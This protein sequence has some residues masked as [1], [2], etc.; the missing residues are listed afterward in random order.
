MANSVAAR[1]C[2]DWCELKHEHNFSKAPPRWSTKRIH[3]TPEEKQEVF[4]K[5]GKHVETRDE[6][7]KV[8]RATGLRDAEKGE[9]C[10][11]MFD[12]LTT[13][14]SSGSR[15]DPKHRLESL[16][17]F[18][19]KARRKPF[20]IHERYEYHRNRLGQKEVTNDNDE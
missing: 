13:S 18:G 16:D 15:L 5:T 1:T 3:M 20:N 7:A 2:W 12:A 14:A 19:E 9:S 4:L 17:L 8:Y 10:Y 6:L 11:E